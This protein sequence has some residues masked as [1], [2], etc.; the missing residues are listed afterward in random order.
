[1]PTHPFERL[2]A[3][4]LR[5]GTIALF[6]TWVMLTIVLGLAVPLE[7]LP[8]VAQMA[9]AGSAA[10]ATAL[11]SEWAT[12]ERQAAS[13]LVGFDFLYDI[14]HNNAVAMG[15]LLASLTAGRGRPV[16]R[17]FAWALWLCTLLNV[18]EN[19][20]FQTVLV[21]NPAD[22]W[23]AFA[24]FIASFRAFVLWSGFLGVLALMGVALISRSRGAS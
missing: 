10:N 8:K 9:A 3:Q 21:G 1:M 20:I 12:E 5:A 13:F 11:L 24:G 7:M 19:L 16:A 15:I 6:A 4:A 14:V 2:S 23:V 17:S 18:A 22:P